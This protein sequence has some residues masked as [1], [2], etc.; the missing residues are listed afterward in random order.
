M[1]WRYNFRKKEDK[2]KL[3]SNS[4]KANLKE[5]KVKKTKNESFQ[6]GKYLWGFLN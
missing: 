6:K 4:Y 2:I 5:P 1:S 3:K